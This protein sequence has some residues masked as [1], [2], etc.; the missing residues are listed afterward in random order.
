MR[1]LATLAIVSV[2]VLVVV[3]QF[4]LPPLVANGV[5][6]R[7]TANGGSADVELNAVPAL[8]LLFTEG[9]SAR[10]RA[11]R[12]ELPLVRPGGKVLGE[13]DGFDDVDVR[14]TD[15]RAGPIR[16]SSFTLTRKG[17]D[18]AYR[19]SI[20]GS[21]T[22]RDAAEFLG[23][24]LG[25]L[26]GGAMPFGDKAVP[27]DLDAVLRSEDGRPH[28]VAVHGTIAGV[29]AGPLVELLAQALAGRF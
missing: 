19:A 26:V 8:R 14:V 22:A 29:S 27:I 5:E 16:L 13:L 11:R 17:G 25:G 1:R 28:A 9:D 6:G 4:A 20:H 18:G 2:L 15:S 10:V 23:G 12:I 21:V 7:L 3:A 24:F